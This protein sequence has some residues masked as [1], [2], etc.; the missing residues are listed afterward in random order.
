MIKDFDLEV[1]DSPGVRMITVSGLIKNTHVENRENHLW[2]RVES[3]DSAESNQ[4]IVEIHP[5]GGIVPNI[6]DLVYAGTAIILGYV[7]HVFYSIANID[8][9]GNY[10]RAKFET[11]STIFKYPIK[12]AGVSTVE[13]RGESARPLYVGL[14]HE[15]VML[16]VLQDCEPKTEVV[17]TISIKLDEN[18]TLPITAQSL[19]DMLQR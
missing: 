12:K 19:E 11:V 15:Q 14:Q 13:I 6:A 16:W 1:C 8:A 9:A 17:T 5:T 4:L 10:G 3:S 7:W 18:V 2:L